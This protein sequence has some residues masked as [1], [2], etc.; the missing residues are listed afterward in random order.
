MPFPKDRN[1][2][3][4][5]RLHV[6][7][8]I[9]DDGIGAALSRESGKCWQQVCDNQQQ[10]L[11]GCVEQGKMLSAKRLD[12]LWF[13]R[14]YYELSKGGRKS[15]IQAAASLGRIS[16]PPSVITTLV[17]AF[18]CLSCSPAP[19]QLQCGIKRTPSQHECVDIAIVTVIA[20]EYR[21]M[22]TKLDTKEVP[23]ACPSCANRYAWV[24]ARIPSLEHR[25]SYRIVIG[26]A[27]EAG[28]VSGALA[29]QRAI[30]RFRPRYVLLVGV[31]G[32][33]PNRVRQ[34]DVLLATS[35]W[36]YDYGA[37]DTEFHPRHDFTFRSDGRLL[38]AALAL[39]TPW[40]DRI[41]K[42]SPEPDYRPERYAGRFGSGNKVI[43]YM[44]SSFVNSIM[45]VN[46]SID[47]VEMEG[48]GAAAAI[49]AATAQ[50][51][52]VGF[53]MIRGIS[54]VPQQVD[55]VLGDKK[56]RE[57]WKLYAADAAASYTLSLIEHNWPEPP[58]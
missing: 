31:A 29:V 43:E 55:P 23:Q 17:L 42:E 37:V 1:A 8:A 46:A 58:R 4:E 20:E 27:G 5:Q 47:G 9:G 51:I 3:I 45:E 56:D 34:G 50:G 21:A 10:V 16:S 38:A 6:T 39:S 22:V 35:I 19:Q 30:T 53:L 52:N 2:A 32:G 57:K 7:S 40:Q 18:V 12:K 33:M 44:G 41:A 36:N 13:N 24:G 54:D 48:A 49:E 11:H 26:M 25:Q 14:K 28:I 15:P